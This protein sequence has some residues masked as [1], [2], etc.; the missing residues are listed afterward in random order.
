MTELCTAA[1]HE[2]IETVHNALGSAHSSTPFHNVHCKLVIAMD[3]VDLL[4]ALTS[5]PRYLY[6][7]GGATSGLAVQPASRR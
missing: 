6:S 1:A 4:K 7:N 2:L 3:G 5:T